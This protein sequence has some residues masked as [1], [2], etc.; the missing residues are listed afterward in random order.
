MLF[1]RCPR[2]ISDRI[3]SAALRL[4]RLARAER[5]LLFGAVL[6]REPSPFAFAALSAGAARAPE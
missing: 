1:L 5:L 4:I 2:R 3:P 6:C